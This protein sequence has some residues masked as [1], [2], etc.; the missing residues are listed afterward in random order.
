MKTAVGIIGVTGYT[1][2]ELLTILLRHPDVSVRYL[3]SRRLRSPVS[4]GDLLPSFR[5]SSSL[6]VY[7]F[8]LK[9]ALDHCD[10]LFLTLPHGVAMEWIPRILR[11]PALR[12]VDLSGDFRLKSASIFKQAYGQRHTS[13]GLLR[14]AVYGLSEWCREAVRGARLVSN[15]GCYP[16]AT[17]LS[18]GPLAKEGLLASQGL[19]VDAKSGVTGA[20]RSPKEELLFSEVNENLRAYNVNA[21]P[22]IPEME[23][24]LSEWAGGPIRMLF[25]PHLVPLNRGLYATVYASLKRRVSEK[26]VR[27]LYGRSYSKEPFIKLL[28]EGVWPQTRSVMGTNNCEINLR[29]DSNGQRVILLSAIDNLGKGAAGQAVQNMNLMYGFPE[30][31]ALVHTAGES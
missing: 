4:V 21:H 20:G 19:I 15:P 30:T 24:T 13:P 8:K 11:K 12:V 17:L 16:T 25:V 26:R 10:L 14:S 6:R 22:H 9:E 18:L 31:A 5:G 29:V 3:A 2:Q 7:P 28:P 27:E 23:Q 1:G